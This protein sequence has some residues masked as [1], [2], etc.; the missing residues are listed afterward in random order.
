MRLSPEAAERSGLWRFSA[1]TPTRGWPR[2]PAGGSDDCSATDQT[3]DR[4]GPDVANLPAIIDYPHRISAVDT[5]YI[6]PQMTASHLLIEQGRAAFVDTGP[7]SAVP[8]LLAAL[9]HRQLASDAVDFV[10]LTHVHLDHAGGAG[11][12]MAAL[13]NATAV[14]HPRGAR[15]MADPSRL[16]TGTRAVYGDTSFERMYGSL[17]PIPGNRI[18]TVADEEVIDWCGRPLRFMHTEGHARHHY[19][20]LDEAHGLIFS[21][22]S[23]GLSYREFDS[24]AGEFILPST[25][26][27]QFDP[28]AALATVDR[29]MSHEPR[30]IFLTHFSRV[31]D[32]ARLAEE[33]KEDIRVYSDLAR[34]AARAD[35]PERALR[36]DLRAWLFRRLDAHGVAEDT[37]WRDSILENDLTLNTQGLLVWLERANGA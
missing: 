25:T 4:T 32:L 1:A 9:E 2:I 23:F 12:L 28:D 37:R 8:E 20:I 27:V 26:P 21:G 10:F 3:H 34:R 35:T 6:R 7:N 30:A 24:D 33:L 5:G 19:C 17:R 22:D 29:L 16:E 13:P 31:T 36:E 15:H 18:R 11:E 14:L